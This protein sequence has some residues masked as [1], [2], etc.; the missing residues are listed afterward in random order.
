MAYQ[1][2][3]YGEPSQAPPAFNP[4]AQGAPP[5]AYGYAPQQQYPPGGYPG[6]PPPGAYPQAQYPPG[7]YPPG[8]YPPG[9]YPPG[10]VMM[11]QGYSGQ[12]TPTPQG[13][14]PPPQP[15]AYAMPG[16]GV[17]QGAGGVMTTVMVNPAS[18]PAPTWVTCPNCG[19]QGLTMI[20]KAPGGA[21][22]GCCCLST[23]AFGLIG[24]L[25]F[26]IC[27]ADD[28]QDVT[29]RCSRCSVPMGTCEKRMC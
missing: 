28:Y 29:H 27:C 26:F 3:Q 10:T 15:G 4:Q 20:T 7:Q 5:G 2:Q 19:T 17:A 9:Q 1:Q 12:P 21:Y 6:Y 22:W 25:S 14:P 18:S 8:Q 23:F 13:G 16:G 11:Q 24:C